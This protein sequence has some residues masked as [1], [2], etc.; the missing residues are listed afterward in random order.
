MRH[1]HYDAIG[2]NR[3]FSKPKFERFR[4]PKSVHPLER[5]KY[6]PIPQEDII[7]VQDQ[8]RVIDRI[9]ALEREMSTLNTGIC[10]EPVTEVTVPQL[11]CL[12]L[13]AIVEVVN[14]FDWMWC[15]ACEIPPAHENQNE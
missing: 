10:P 9:R 6:P 12:R 5:L 8:S 7:A 14:T 3:A 4:P 1:P 2:V 11:K 15:L 13:I